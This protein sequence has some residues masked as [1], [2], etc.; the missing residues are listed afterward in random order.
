M[1]DFLGK[2]AGRAL[3]P[4]TALKPRLLSAFE[5]ANPALAPLLAALNPEDAPEPRPTAAAEAVPRSRSVGAAPNPAGESSAESSPDLRLRPAAGERRQPMPAHRPAAP[6]ALPGAVIHP[7]PPTPPVPGQRHEAVAAFQPR[8]GLGRA[9][10]S[11]QATPLASS[12]VVP[13]RAAQPE[14]NPTQPSAG[15]ASRLQPPEDGG[16]EKH[17]EPTLPALNTILAG[18]RPKLTPPSARGEPRL[19]P[20][21]PST[22]HVTIGRLEV[23]AI[24]PPAPVP[25]V[26]RANS[27]PALGLKE[28]LER[29]KGGP[30]R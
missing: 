26:R 4:D 19:R 8:P 20:E 22:I 30:A 16:P 11:E 2:L 3:A 18:L 15:K 10:G 14:A 29:R 25:P 6:D 28:Y 27:A 21:A 9:A 7:L 23:R 13:R 17:R 12:P 1:N 24:V 5:P